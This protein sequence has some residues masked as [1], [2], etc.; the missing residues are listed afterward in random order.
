MERFRKAIGSIIIVIVLL[1]SL[2]CWAN[3]E[4]QLPADH[5]AYFAMMRLMDVSLNQELPDISRGERLTRFE[6]AYYI[7]KYLLFWDANKDKI[8]LSPEQYQLLDRLIL[9]FKPELEMLGLKITDLSGL[10]PTIQFESPGDVDYSDLD[11]LLSDP[12]H[13]MQGE[14]K[15]GEKIESHDPYYVVGEYFTT[16][17]DEK[18]FFFL[19]ESYIQPSI[20]VAMLSKRWEIVHTTNDDPVL[21]FLVFM[22]DLPMDNKPVKG[23]FLFPLDLPMK[24]YNVSWEQKGYALLQQLSVGYKINNLWQKKGVI[25]LAKLSSQD[26]TGA[27]SPFQVGNYLISTN[28]QEVSPII[29]PIDVTPLNFED[30]DLLLIQPP[31]QNSE[32]DLDLEMDI[33][34]SDNWVN[35]VFRRQQLE[36]KSLW[37]SSS[38]EWESEALDTFWTSSYWGDIPGWSWNDHIAWLMMQMELLTPEDVDNSGALHF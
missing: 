14:G 36:L 5:W 22:G 6:V 13:S 29:Q 8:S 11:L 26:N 4:L 31:S 23:L 33:S 37:G 15:E 30:L 10:V 20:D 25:P 21:Y 32:N 2:L 34:L 38:T 3:E 12:L 1:L 19:P 18:T 7:K 9:E 27:Y 24:D 35:P 17:F 16:D 28:T